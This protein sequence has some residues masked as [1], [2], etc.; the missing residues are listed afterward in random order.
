M[1]DVARP[2]WS[3]G[4]RLFHWL[5]VLIL[6]FQLVVAFGPMKGPGMASMN[7]LPAHMSAGVLILAIIVLRLGWR[8]VTKAPPQPY[9]RSWHRARTVFHMSIYALILAVL[10]TGWLAY[11]PMPFMPPAR[12]FGD[13]PVPIAPSVGPSSAR[14]FAFIHA[15]LV[16]V[17]L[18][19][20]GIH[21]AAALVHLA[22]FRDDIM[23]GM[24]FG[25]ATA[26][27]ASEE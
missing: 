21:I 3:F 11:R 15:K 6:A 10:I 9:S 4:I 24:S 5:T 20:I 23:R 14:A 26:R 16:W 8:A 17:L 2:R 25:R 12:L 18:G 7:W 22:W 27:G 1:R 19:F 13:V